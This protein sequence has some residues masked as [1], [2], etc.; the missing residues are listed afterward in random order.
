MGRRGFR[1]R[2]VWM[3]RREEGKQKKKRRG[4]LGRGLSWLDRFCFFFLFP[5]S[6]KSISNQNSEIEFFFKLFST[7]QTFEI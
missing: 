2:G 4:G 7:F 3:G 6:F 5:F 1:G